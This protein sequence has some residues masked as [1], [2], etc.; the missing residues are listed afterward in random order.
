MNKQELRKKYS[1]LRKNIIDR[2]EKNRAITQKLNE[3]SVGHQFIFTYVSFGS[4]VDTHEFI[5]TNVERVYVPY[6]S[7]GNMKCLKYLGGELKTDKLG[8]L[9]ASCY[10]AEGDP[11]LTIVPML[12]FD[13]S[14]F[15]LGYGGGYYDRFLQNSFTVKVGVAYD[16]QLTE[17]NFA[18]IF[19]VPLDI[20]VTPTQI[21]KRQKR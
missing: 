14:C 8:N 15:R 19:D 1:V 9:D 4:E 7:N 13:K 6:T 5:K 12:A 11:T 17:E 21:Y 20:I 3:L 16:E 10:G 2:E 18:E